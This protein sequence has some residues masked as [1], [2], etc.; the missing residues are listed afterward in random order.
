M[1]VYSKD[2]RPKVLAAVDCGVPQARAVEIFG[3]SLT[4][5]KRWLKRRKEART[6]RTGKTGRRQRIPITTEE[7][8]ASGRG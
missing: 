3:V 5:P 2:L 1:G 4:T 7:R 6:V 8:R